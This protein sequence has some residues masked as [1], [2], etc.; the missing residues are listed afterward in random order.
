MVYVVSLCV[1][2]VLEYIYW[3]IYNICSTYKYVSYV[4]KLFLKM[5]LLCY[6]CICI[7]FKLYDIYVYVLLCSLSF[8]YAYKN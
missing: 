1:D 5:K 2:V 4:V 8:N 3:Y 7:Y 6:Y